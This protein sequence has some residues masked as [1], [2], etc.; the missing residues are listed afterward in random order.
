MVHGQ[1]LFHATCAQFMLSLGTDIGFTAGG[2]VLKSTNGLGGSCRLL[3]QESA[4]F[5]WSSLDTSLFT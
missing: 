2:T 4:L 3:I 1:V 5:T